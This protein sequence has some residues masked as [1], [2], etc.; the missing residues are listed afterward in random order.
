MRRLIGTALAI[1]VAPCVCLGAGSGVTVRQLDGILA[2]ARAKGSSDHRTANAI[3]H[4]GLTERL[5]RATQSRLSRGVG[6]STAEALELLADR[7]AFLDPPADEI[8]PGEPPS[9]VERQAILERAAAYVLAYVKN[10]PNMVCTRVVSRF[11]EPD[12]RYRGEFSHLDT[13]TGELTVRDGEESFRAGNGGANA[14]SGPDHS[15][16]D[17]MTSGDYGSIL[18]EPFAGHATFTWHRWETVDG[19]RVAVVGYSVPRD[20]SLFKVSWC[21]ELGARDDGGFSQRAAYQGEM[22]IDAASGAVLRVTEQAVGLSAD[23]PVKRTWT[24]VE[25][26]PVT[27]GGGSFLVPAKSV[28]F[29]EALRW[30]GRIEQ[31]LNRSEFRSYHKFEAESTVA[32]EAPPET[33][34]VS[35]ASAPHTPGAGAPAPATPGGATSATLPE[36]LPIPAPSAAASSV[37]P[38][39][40]GSTPQAA[41]SPTKEDT[42]SAANE[43]VF[44]VHSEEIPVRVVV[45]DERGNAVGDL[46]QEDFELFDSGKPQQLTGFRV[47]RRGDENPPSGKAG[48]GTQGSAATRPQPAPMPQRYVMF[49][50]DDLNLTFDEIMSTHAATTRAIGNALEPGTRVALLTESGKQHI[51]FTDDPAKLEDALNRVAPQTPPADFPEDSQLG[52]SGRIPRAA[53]QPGPFEHAH[54]RALLKVI[55]AAVRRLAMMPGERSIVFVS[56]GF[57]IPVGERSDYWNLID[58]AARRGIPINTLDP[59][60]VWVFPGFGAEHQKIDANLMGLFSREVEQSL[61]LRGLADGTGGIAVRS[62]NDFDGGFKRIATRP[63]FT[64]MLAFSPP[65]LVPDGKYHKLK[66][67]VRNRRGVTVQAR[68]GYLAPDRKLTEAEQAAREIDEA[69]YSRGETR[70]I[71]VTV[72]GT[73]PA[74]PAAVC[75]SLRIG[76]GSTR[77][78]NVGGRSRAS[79]TATVGLFDSN[80]IYV[81]GK[82]DNLDLD[83]AGGKVPASVQ[84]RG[85]FHAAPGPCVVRVV[86]RDQDGQMSS[87]NR[88]VEV[89]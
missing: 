25:Y 37:T 63:E 30:S 38:P 83:Y 10:L 3:A 84:V 15:R 26:M 11:E 5:T 74:K 86:V 68:D 89:R 34:P 19:R 58:W 62:T 67:E 52:L 24:T 35:I 48:Q 7:S 78:T 46:R 82:Q 18:S 81:D 55:E 9:P 72:A 32:F 23:F 43:P 36:P 54:F 88:T 70:E 8:V 51:D 13:L 69:V 56:P 16:Q 47:E 1:F 79:L 22:S 20:G 80:G 87:I 57:P 60:G 45:R 2:A 17:L 6:P 85:G 77:F 53:P 65:E 28:T 49:L 41:P 33:P 42:P 12:A 40:N 61:D 71:P 73:C 59:R 14:G 27:L 4:L 39:A 31:Y 21:C 44:R 50:F 29:M 75:V 66:V 76:L 64:Y